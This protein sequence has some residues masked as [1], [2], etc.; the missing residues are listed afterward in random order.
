[1][2]LKLVKQDTANQAPEHLS[3][4]TRDLWQRIVSDYQIDDDAG[5]LLLTSAMEALDRLRDCQKS[6][7]RDG[8]TVRGSQKQPR[9]HPLLSV[10]RDARSQMLASLKALNLDLEPLRDGPGRPPGA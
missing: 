8:V 7:A 10:E 1:M 6:I 9:A 5:Q 4:E 2:T 3:D